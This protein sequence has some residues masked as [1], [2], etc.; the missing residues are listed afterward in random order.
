MTYTIFALSN[1]DAKICHSKTT[2][3][4]VG[5]VDLIIKNLQDRGFTITV[6]E[7]G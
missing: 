3:T 4:D 7:H 1:D 6:E 5:L 2:T